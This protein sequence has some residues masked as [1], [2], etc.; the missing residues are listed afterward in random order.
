LLPTLRP[1]ELRDVMRHP[2][3]FVPVALVVLAAAGMLWADVPWKE[4]LKGFTPFA[5]FLV[6][7]LLF[8]QYRNS[9]RWRGLFCAFLV[10]CTVLM[11][12][13]FAGM[14]SGGSFV[15][16]FKTHGVP[17]RDYISQSGVFILSAAGLF[18]VAMAAWA[19]RKTLHL[20]GALALA[21][22]FLVNVSFVA[23]SRTALVTIPVLLVLFAVTQCRLKAMLA[24]LAGIAVLCAIVWVSSVRVQERITGIITEIRSHKQNNVETSAGLRVDFWRQ[25]LNVMKAAPILGHGT[26]SVRDALSRAAIAEGNTPTVNPHNQSFTIGIQLGFAGMLL[27]F[28]MWCAQATLFLRGAGLIAW[29]GLAIV[30]QNVV[31]CLFNNHLFDFTQAWLYLFGVGVAGGAVLSQSHGLSSSS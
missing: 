9:D 24:F 6:L 1:Q 2:A 5:R 3:A 19:E 12:L 13:S 21:A 28:A 25:S 26:G 16:R 31:G 18:Y 15:I 8:V 11:A 27:L 20:F 4:R 23:P 17:V 22:L 7:P 14:A 29:V 10:S 30:A